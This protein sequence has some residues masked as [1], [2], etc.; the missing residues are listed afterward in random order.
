VAE[1]RKKRRPKKQKTM[2]AE[3]LAGRLA[4]VLE[5]YRDRWAPS[6]M[7]ELARQ[8]RKLRIRSTARRGQR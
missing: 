5:R 1:A 7:A 2:L 8:L 6:E 3:K 4:A